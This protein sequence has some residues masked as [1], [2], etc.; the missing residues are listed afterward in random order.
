MDTQLILKI[1]GIG[2]LVAVTCQILTRSGRDEQSMLL[3][4]AG[5]VIVLLIIMDK[6]GSLL[7]SVKTIFGI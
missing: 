3:S 1:A 7:T 4:I 6:I 5:V 2:I